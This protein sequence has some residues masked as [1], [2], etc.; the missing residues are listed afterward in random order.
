MK[1]ETWFGEAVQVRVREAVQRAEQASRGQVVPVVVPRSAGYG[2]VPF[3]GAL[4]AAA[5]A[6]GVALLSRPP[7]SAA[8]LVL[9]QVAAGVA[10][11]LLGRWSPAA[12]LLA[13]PNAMEQA[14]RARAMR[15]FVEQGVHRTAEGAG[16]LLFASLFERRAVVLG[17]HGIHAKVGDAEWD[18]TVT[19]LVDGIRRGDPGQGFVDAISLCGARLAEHF[20]RAPGTAAQPNELSDAIRVERS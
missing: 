10:G 11:A 19:A 13:G 6:T 1:L 9:I 2:E 18:R 7:P 20:P 17:D 5:L 15:A 16:V 12:R 3:R 8:V 4:L 14:V